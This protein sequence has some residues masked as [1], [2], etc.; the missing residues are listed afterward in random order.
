MVGEGD[1][2]VSDCPRLVQFPARL[3]GWGRRAL[4]NLPGLEVQTCRAQVGGEVRVEA[5]PALDLR[6]EPIP[7]G[8]ARPKLDGLQAW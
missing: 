6:L 4:R 5:A 8:R 7:G 2:E 3:E 1:L